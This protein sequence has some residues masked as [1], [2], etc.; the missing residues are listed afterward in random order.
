MKNL[1]INA[2]IAAMLI[3]N[4]VMGTYIYWN[5]KLYL[6]SIGF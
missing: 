5:V 3:A 6:V 2:A 4:F 1:L